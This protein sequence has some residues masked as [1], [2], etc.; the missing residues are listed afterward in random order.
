MG[1]DT[2]GCLPE[3]RDNE[4]AYLR[5]SMSNPLARHIYQAL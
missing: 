2:F 3:D 5:R 4:I 1:H